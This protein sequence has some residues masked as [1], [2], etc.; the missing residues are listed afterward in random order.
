M[1]GPD[2]PTW[3]LSLANEFRRL[4]TGI[5]KPIPK[6]DRIEGTGTMFLT[7][8]DRIPKDRRITYANFIS[9]IRP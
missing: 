7:M 8:K 1:H 3:T 2:G 5:G 4:C 9:N 6:T